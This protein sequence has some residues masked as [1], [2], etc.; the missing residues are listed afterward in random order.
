MKGFWFH[1]QKTKQYLIKFFYLVEGHKYTLEKM[2]KATSL[3]SAREAAKAH[4][5]ILIIHFKANRK[6]DIRIEIQE[7][8]LQ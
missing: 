7:I 2:I 1:A 5:D 4:C 6:S 3:D 8:E